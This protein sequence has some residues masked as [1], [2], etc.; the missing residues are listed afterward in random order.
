MTFVVNFLF[1]RNCSVRICSIDMEPHHVE[2]A[3]IGPD[4]HV[5]DVGFVC[6][7]FPANEARKEGE[8]RVELPDEVLHVFHG[9][10]AAELVRHATGVLVRVL[11]KG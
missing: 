6:D 7:F 11:L 8:G 10:Q 9:D 2:V 4:E 5:A 3:I 1:N